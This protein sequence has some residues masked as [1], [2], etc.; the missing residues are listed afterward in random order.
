M[1][2]VRGGYGRYCH[3]GLIRDTVRLLGFW[4]WS[5]VSFEFFLAFRF[6][7]PNAQCSV[8]D[9]DDDTND[10]CQKFGQLKNV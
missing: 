4:A 7:F 8:K 10:D 1:A 3:V 2:T 6:C 9:I 5:R